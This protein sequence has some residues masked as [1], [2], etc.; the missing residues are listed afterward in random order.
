MFVP[1][2]IQKNIILTSFFEKKLAASRH[3]DA[4]L[5]GFYQLNV[6]EN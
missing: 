4:G 5:P 6:C 1:A 2:N 3:L